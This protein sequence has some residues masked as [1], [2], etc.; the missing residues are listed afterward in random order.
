MTNVS[1]NA[2]EEYNCVTE[3]SV[4]NA[5][6]EP[7]SSVVAQFHQNTLP[8][9]VETTPI[10]I[11]GESESLEFMEDQFLTNSIPEVEL[12]V[13]AAYCSTLG[14]LTGLEIKQR[15]SIF[16]GIQ[17]KCRSI[18]AG[19]AY[20]MKP[21]LIYLLHHVHE[22]HIEEVK[23]FLSTDMVDER[24]LD[25]NVFPIVIGKE[26][27][28]SQEELNVW[29]EEHNYSDICKLSVESAANDAMMGRES[30]QDN[31][32]VT[33]VD[34]TEAGE[35]EGQSISPV[36]EQPVQV[37]LS[38][39][40]VIQ[41]NL[42]STTDLIVSDFG[43]PNT[44][45]QLIA[46]ALEIESFSPKE[47][48]TTFSS[49]IASFMDKYP[50]RACFDP[51]NF[52]N[53][54]A[55]HQR[56]LQACKDSSQYSTDVS[57]K[58]ADAP[59][60]I[61]L[62]S[63][64]AKGKQ[65]RRVYIAE[66]AAIAVVCKY[67]PQF[68]MNG[69]GSAIDS[70][71]MPTKYNGEIA[72]VNL[73]Q[74]QVRSYI[75]T[76]LS[77]TLPKSIIT[78]L[79]GT[80]L[81]PYIRFKDTKA[82]QRFIGRLDDRITAEGLTDRKTSLLIDPRKEHIM[83][84]VR[85]ENSVINVIDFC[86]LCLVLG[87]TPQWLLGKKSATLRDEG[88]KPVI[89][90][91]EKI[92]VKLLKHADNIIAPLV[93]VEVNDHGQYSSTPYDWELHLF[94][95]EFVRFYDDEPLAGA[96]SSRAFRLAL[97]KLSKTKLTGALLPAVC[98]RHLLKRVLVDFKN[99]KQFTPEQ[100]CDIAK[101][102][103]IP[104][105]ALLEGQIQPIKITAKKPKEKVKQF[106]MFNEFDF[107]SSILNRMMRASLVYDAKL[108][109][110]IRNLIF[111]TPCLN[112]VIPDTEKSLDCVLF[113]IELQCL[114]L[115]ID[116]AKLNRMLTMNYS[117]KCKDYR[118]GHNNLSVSELCGY[119]F[120][121]GV[122][123]QWLLNGTGKR[124]DKQQRPHFVDVEDPKVRKLHLLY[125]LD[126]FLK[127][128]HEIALA[129]EVTLTLS[130]FYQINGAA[131]KGVSDIVIEKKQQQGLAELKL[132]IENELSN[133]SFTMYFLSLFVFGHDKELERIFNQKKFITHKQIAA[134]SQALN[135]RQNWLLLGKE[136]KYI[137]DDGPSLICKVYHQIQST[138]QDPDL[139]KPRKAVEQWLNDPFNET[140]EI[141]SELLADICNDSSLSK[142]EINKRANEQI[143]FGSKQ[144][145]DEFVSRL[146][147]AT[148]ACGLDDAK[149]SVA[150]FTRR[151]AISRFTVESRGFT[152]NFYRRKELLIFS[153]ALG[154]T[155]QWLLTGKGSISYEAHEPWLKKIPSFA[156]P[157][158]A[159]SRYPTHLVKKRNET[160]A[161]KTEEVRQ[162]RKRLNT[163]HDN[164]ESERPVSKK[165]RLRG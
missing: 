20:R 19:G 101:V 88:Q 143:R 123:P 111:N 144:N 103:G 60:L 135:L 125:H 32:Q 156:V 107:E 43:L 84:W 35:I 114:V 126:R 160:L 23:S 17:R 8:I 140:C 15:L 96:Y 142:E 65:L 146:K 47:R 52:P 77:K 153:L 86:A 79:S 2:V 162:A 64:S 151:E 159:N 53:M 18:E 46:L 120:I 57:S 108:P 109:M 150:C 37:P 90:N 134:I 21:E 130:T 91:T 26:Q 4:G 141:S 27:N 147:L 95:G 76:G 1:S 13:E 102:L 97:V 22:E 161:V 136:P 154:V 54:Q 62:L 85:K 92:K 127:G 51:H 68:L 5:S 93:G 67:R 6:V 59:H 98:I 11:E 145:I 14:V 25:L 70:E 131:K 157:P 30:G 61:K 152:R 71:A 119:A 73:P 165:A 164:S 137:H 100:I 117:V 112:K 69:T 34:M 87:C 81:S 24:L 138:Y 94:D 42:S 31:L 149:I 39:N 10:G 40:A 63:P 155:Q 58:V 113:R 128:K 99:G 9:R 132:R 44:K 163:F 41:D 16:E 33:D 158:Q 75:H 49:S 139:N 118:N 29:C 3:T 105:I 7:S 50:P 45:K 129:S 115:G 133:Q 116:K 148:Q 124:I 83:P 82:H 110:S 104:A 55:L 78:F 121:L 56:I 72:I 12:L 74:R 89:Y 28:F 48:K 66:I 80:R 106:H 36:L 38:S 122:R